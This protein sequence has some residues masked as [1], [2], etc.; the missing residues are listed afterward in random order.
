MVPAIL[1]DFNTFYEGGNWI[2]LADEIELP[3][4]V[5]KMEELYMG[6]GP[7]KV[8]MG[9]EALE[10]TVSLNC[11]VEDIFTTYGTC[12]VSDLALRF[13]GAHERQD[14]TCETQSIEMVM[15]GRTSELDSG[16]AKKGDKHQYKFK[17]DL[18][19]FKVIVDNVTLIEIDHENYIEVVGGD[20]RLART[21][22]AIG[23]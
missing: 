16:T 21:R 17:M 11:Y 5:K 15:R 7:L 9:N 12:G 1:K 2:G 13:A 22:A 8:A 19:Y 6:N 23:L 14:A 18:A 4:L 20:D 10:S 3:K